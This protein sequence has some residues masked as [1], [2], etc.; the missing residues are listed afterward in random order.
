MVD[1]SLFQHQKRSSSAECHCT[2]SEYHY[3]F[4][5]REDL[6]GMFS[7]LACVLLSTRRCLI[8]LYKLAESHRESSLDL[9]EV[10][11]LK[12]A[13]EREIGQCAWSSRIVLHGRAPGLQPLKICTIGF[14]AD[15]TYECDRVALFK[16]NQTLQGDNP[17]VKSGT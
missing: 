7:R 1:I 5:R 8:G 4:N 14:H 3:R 9:I 2:P 15:L 17:D 6:A 11:V 12:A 13:L 16:K 10:H